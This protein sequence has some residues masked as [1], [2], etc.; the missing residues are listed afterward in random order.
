MHYVQ[1][2]GMLI[3]VYRRTLDQEP[4]FDVR[5]WDRDGLLTAHSSVPHEI[6]FAITA[7]SADRQS[8]SR[9][10]VIVRGD[11]VELSYEDRTRLRP[12]LPT[13]RTTTTFV[14][15]DTRFGGRRRWLA[16]PG[17]D[18]PCCVLYYA[19]LRFVCARCARCCLPYASQC[20]TPA[21]RMRR[22]AAKGRHKLNASAEIAP[23]AIRRPKHMRRKTFDY[24][25][26]LIGHEERQAKL[27]D[28]KALFG[29]FNWFKAL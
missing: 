16:C 24:L 25:R 27:R 22:R 3:A 29:R 9:V 15:T 12:D 13:V 18:R 19:T 14:Y 17:C 10:G 5:E 26:W 7:H 20:E 4:R 8:S 28:Y 1:R 21:D 2:D 11:V 23:D 6:T